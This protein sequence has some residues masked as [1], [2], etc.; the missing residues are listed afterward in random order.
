MSKRSKKNAAPAAVEQQENNDAAVETA[1]VETPATET[2]VETA[3]TVD[4]E[5]ELTAE[6]VVA[7]DVLAMLAGDDATDEPAAA[8][9][10]DAPAAADAEIEVDEPTDD[11]VLA[12]INQAGSKSS[13]TKQPKAPPVITRDFTA[14]A[15]IDRATLDA[16]LAACNAKKV[17]EKA[18]NLIAAVQ[19]GKKLSRYT[20]VAVKQLVANGAIS[21]KDMV[22]AFLNE[23]LKEGT[24][25]AQAQQM[26][27][28]FRLVGAV[29]PDAT[30]KGRLVANDAGLI[31]ELEA[32]AA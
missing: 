27:A 18:E 19:S 5:V 29:V 21:G 17:R 4:A 1:T 16:N 3:E 31:K 2:T 24:A 32:L 13:G 23:G 15:Q 11:E 7:D 10:E 6:P 30:T 12:T 9:T 25:R 28:L 22:A 26:T 14:V 8:T 20:Q